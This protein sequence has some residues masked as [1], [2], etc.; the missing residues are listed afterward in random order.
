M[1]QPVPPHP[2]FVPPPVPAP[3]R[4]KLSARLQRDED[5]NWIGKLLAV[6]G[7]AVTLVGVVLLLVLAAQAGVLRPEI[8]VAAGAVLAAGL[9]VVGVRLWHR[10]GGQVGG[11]AL[12][13]TGVA[14]AYMDVIAITT[15]Y[16]WVSPGFGLVTAA[17]IGGG[18]LTLARRWNSQ[19]LALLV[20]VP[21]IVLA[22]IVGDGVTLLLIGFMTALS[23]AALPVQ[24]GRDWLWM[25]AA[26][27]VGVTLPLLAALFVT[28]VSGDR[29]DGWLLGGACGVAALL[30]V[31]SSIVLLP[32]TT[33]P[34]AMGLLT[35][36]GVLP[37]LAAGGAVPRVL[38]V[39]LAT[40][41][42]AA[43]LALSTAGRRLAGVTTPVVVIWSAL[44]AF[45][46]L[47]AVTAAFDGEV[48]APVLLGMALVVT[49]AGRRSR[50]AAWIGLAFAAVGGL[51]FLAYAPPGYLFEGTELAVPLAISNIVASSLAIACAAAIG[52]TWARPAHLAGDGVRMLWIGSGLVALYSITMF[53]VTTGV[54]IA[55]ADGGFLAGHMAAT[56][57]WI[58]GAAVLLVAARRMTGPQERIAGVIGGL[59]LTVAAT[60]KL[61][62]FDLGTLDGMFRVAAFIVVGL[63]LLGM[64]TG[65][66]RS[67]AQGDGAD[68]A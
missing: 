66:A 26:R 9:V 16:G 28:S 1:P 21:L 15:I 52:Y 34:T 55:G 62:L 27:T 3:P 4:R 46:A 48:E 40:A 22:P 43:M 13:A 32:T 56:I 44:S 17:V 29:G 33:R 45:A 25:H 53:T 35:V 49:L 63:V 23:A 5:Q 36:V 18:G 38:A 2:G 64:G 12:T 68:S 7:V 65:Y 50:I 51:A 6:A 61:F 10:P 39:L 30:A 41:V 19:Q 57:C 59:S 8:R 60:A 14:A 58:G 42:A 47:I 11:V 54:L 67:L 20:L 31:L 24:L 37:A